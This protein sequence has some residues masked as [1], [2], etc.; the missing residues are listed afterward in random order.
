MQ[1]AIQFFKDALRHEVKASAFYN[2]AVEVTRDDESRML[3]IKLAGIEDGHTNALL[4]KVKDAPCGKSF[5]V[6]AF[7]KE[8]EANV[9]PAISP[10]ESKLIESG[11]LSEVLDL[12]IKLEQQA[13]KDYEGLAKE[14][15][16]LDVKTYSRELAEEERKHAQELTNLLNSLEMS[17]DDRPGL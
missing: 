2:K 6:D 9:V 3:F 12:A 10:E 13:I 1:A 7:L 14:S 5:D 17:E 4:D 16:H 11:T 8:L 15:V